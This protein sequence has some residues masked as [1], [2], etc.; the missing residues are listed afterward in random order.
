VREPRFIPVWSFAV[1][2]AGGLVVTA[3]AVPTLAHPALVLLTPL[4]VFLV[5][6]TAFNTFGGDRGAY[7]LHLAAGVRPRDDLA[8]RNLAGALLGLA[9][10]VLT[11]L[12]VAAATHGWHYVAVALGVAV[13]L[14]GITHGVA[15]PTSAWAAFPLPETSSNLW[16]ARPGQGCVTG[17]AL[18]AGMAAQA[19]L[20]VP[21][22]V[23]VAV[24][25]GTAPAAL[26]LVSAAAAAYGLALWWAGLQIAAE[27]VGRRSPELLAVLS[28]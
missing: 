21:V 24:A 22:V 3:L 9:L 12:P 27:S 10:V 5:A 7:W 14:L 19:L 4:P 13:G 23:A 2:I 17:L 20:T 18:L 25:A 16:A 15:N 6:L 28:S 11:A 26:P 8:G 1:L